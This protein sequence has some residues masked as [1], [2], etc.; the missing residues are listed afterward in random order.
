MNLATQTLTLLCL[1]I[2]LVAGASDRLKLPEDYKHFTH[3]VQRSKT[4]GHILRSSS[5][6]REFMRLS[7][8]PSGRAGYQIDHIV[9]LKRHGFDCP[10]NMQWIPTAAKKIKD[11]YE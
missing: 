4:T 1:S 10:C 11:K 6:R 3:E 7:G 8:H 5:A 2:A 9:P